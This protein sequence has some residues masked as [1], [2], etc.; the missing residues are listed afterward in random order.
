ML[1][2]FQISVVSAIVVQGHS[3]VD[4]PELEPCCSDLLTNPQSKT[5]TR[6]GTTDGDQEIRLRE[7]TK[8]ASVLTDLPMKNAT[9][10]TCRAGGVSD[11]PSRIR[12]YD[13][14]IKSQLLYQLSYRSGW[15]GGGMIT[16]TCRR[17]KGSVTKVEIP[18]ITNPCDRFWWKTR[19]S[20]GQNGADFS[21]FA[22]SCPSRFYP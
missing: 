3:T 8:R 10:R 22:T 11:A 7:G 12:T 13:L 18:K 15:F 9:S 1:L 2:G 16:V 19:D 5:A 17:A 21:E 6:S 14:R 20:E 4:H